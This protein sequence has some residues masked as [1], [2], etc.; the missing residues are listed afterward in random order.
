MLI[1]G[2]VILDKLHIMP[3]KKAHKVLLLWLYGYRELNSYISDRNIN[4]F[5]WLPDQIDI[6]SKFC[7]YQEFI[8]KVYE[9]PRLEIEMI[10][11]NK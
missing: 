1:W 7:M 10:G 4:T 9:N 2:G 11:S 5:K 3:K 6:F 8:G